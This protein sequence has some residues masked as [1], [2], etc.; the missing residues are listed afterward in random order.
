MRPWQLI[1]HQEIAHHK[2]GMIVLFLWTQSCP[3]THTFLVVSRSSPKC[4]L[5]IVGNLCREGLLGKVTTWLLVGGRSKEEDTVIS[6]WMNI[7]QFFSIYYSTLIACFTFYSVAAATWLCTWWMGIHFLYC[8]PVLPGKSVPMCSYNF[9][10]HL[11]SQYLCTCCIDTPVMNMSS[12]LD[13]YCH[14]T[15]PCDPL[16][17][18]DERPRSRTGAPYSQGCWGRKVS[19]GWRT[20]WN[21]RQIQDW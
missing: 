5:Q 1:I 15:P 18:Q 19:F 7:S 6:P 10:V 13:I 17:L 3:S 14:A 8:V 21:F 20:T 2:N 16:R 12:E 11:M 9:P 4:C